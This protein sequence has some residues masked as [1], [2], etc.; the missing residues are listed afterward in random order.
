MNIT[1]LIDNKKRHID[2][3]LLADEQESMIDRYLERGDIFVLDDNGVKAI[4]VVTDEG[5]GVCELKNIAVTPE[6]QRQGYGKRLINYLVTHYSGKYTRM[7]VGT[8]DVPSTVNF[9]K[10]C[11]FEYSHRIKNFFTDN[12]DHLMIEDGVL[13]KDMIYLKREI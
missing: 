11:K 12:Y 9:Y 10:S 2:L 4:C 8:G 6:S 13:L 7:I 3:L 5:D 1:Q